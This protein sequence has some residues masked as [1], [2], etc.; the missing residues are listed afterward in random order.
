MRLRATSPATTKWSWAMQESSC[1]EIS[2]VHQK[3]GAPIV[4]LVQEKLTRQCGLLLR[5]GGADGI[6][7]E[8][9]GGDIRG[10]DTCDGGRAEEGGREPESAEVT[11]RVVD[12]LG[13]AILPRDSVLTST[14]RAF[15]L[16][17]RAK[18]SR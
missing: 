9:G 17:S 2:S 1:S 14:G 7:G 8:A 18:R 16:T 15:L 11:L 5:T 4:A 3:E 12:R 10:V 13:G 6:R